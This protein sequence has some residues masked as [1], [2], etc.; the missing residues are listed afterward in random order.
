MK[1]SIYTIKHTIYSGETSRVSLPTVTGEVTILDHHVP[2]VTLLTEGKVRYGKVV[3]SG[4]GTKE[5]E[6]T[7]LIKGGFLEVRD[8]NEVRVLADE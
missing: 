1:L 5:E 2:Y 4:A 3:P 8:N 6:E 7:I